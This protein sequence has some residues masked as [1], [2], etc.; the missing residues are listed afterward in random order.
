MMNQDNDLVKQMLYFHH[1]CNNWENR[2]ESEIIPLNEYNLHSTV[3]DRFHMLNKYLVPFSILFQL[4]NIK[5]VY[6]SV[7]QE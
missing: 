4:P 7:S 3:T 5:F 1:F 6:S 2:Y